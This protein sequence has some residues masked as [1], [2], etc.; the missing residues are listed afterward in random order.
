MCEVPEGGLVPKSLYRT[1]EELEN[2][3]IKLWTETI[4]QS[5]SVFKGAPHE[6]SLALM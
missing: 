3:D 4:Y 5:A 1:P 2:D 6:A